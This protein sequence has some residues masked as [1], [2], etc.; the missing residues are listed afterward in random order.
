MSSLGSNPYPFDDLNLP[1]DN[2]ITGGPKLL[3][4]DS[5]TT[6]CGS[7]D[8]CGCCC[9]INGCVT[10]TSIG[11][12]WWTSIYAWKSY[13]LSTSSYFMCSCWFFSVVVTRGDLLL[14]NLICYKCSLLSWSCYELWSLFSLDGICMV[15]PIVIT[16]VGIIFM[17][18]TYWGLTSSP[19]FLHIILILL[20]PQMCSS[21][22]TEI[23]EIPLLLP[24]YSSLNPLDFF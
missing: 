7:W 19:N 14:S 18:M 10:C 6:I 24:S 4:V 20:Q 11:A 17:C 23:L 3:N 5:N 16:H 9:S 21:F 12:S 8:G 22:S 1:C 13:K 2:T 15:I